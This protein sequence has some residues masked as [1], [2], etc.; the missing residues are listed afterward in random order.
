[1]CVY[2]YIYLRMRVIYYSYLPYIPG[3]LLVKNQLTYR[4]GALVVGLKLYFPAVFLARQSL[5]V[6]SD[7]I[8]AITIQIWLVV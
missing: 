3:C 6:P 5:Q 8:R 1:M 7:C 2:V 4:V